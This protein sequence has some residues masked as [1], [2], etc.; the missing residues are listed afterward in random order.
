MAHIWEALSG[1][2]LA[3]KQLFWAQIFAAFSEPWV[4]QCARVKPCAALVNWVG[5][6]EEGLRAVPVPTLMSAGPHLPAKSAVQG[7]VLRAQTNC[8]RPFALARSDARCVPVGD[9]RSCCRVQHRQ[10]GLES[11]RLGFPDPACLP[12]QIPVVGPG[13]CRA[14]A[15]PARSARSTAW[16]QRISNHCNSPAVTASAAMTHH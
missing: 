4:A 10:H 13:T 8:F 6:V 16:A 5:A 9:M 3:R 2:S 1:S 12:P 15:E 7:L 11:M 14:L